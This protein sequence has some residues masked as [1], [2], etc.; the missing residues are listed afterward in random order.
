MFNKILIIIIL[1]IIGYIVI[2]NLT[3]LNSSQENFK[4]NYPYVDK[5]GIP[6]TQ[7]NIPLNKINNEIKNNFFKTS[8]NNKKNNLNKKD[9]NEIILADT[10]DL[11]YYHNDVINQGNIYEDSNDIINQID[12]IDYGKITTGIDKCKKLCNGVCWENGYTGVATC[13][14]KSPL[15]DFGTLYKNPTFAYGN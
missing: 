12:K 6:S 2:F 8:L 11:T 5:R 10:K 13:Y 3:L 7:I 4:E 15:F 14:P 1:I 9:Y